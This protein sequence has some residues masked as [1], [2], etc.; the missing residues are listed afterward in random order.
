MGPQNGPPM[1]LGRKRQHQQ[2]RSVIQ[3]TLE[4][5][6]AWAQIQRPI[7][8]KLVLIKFLQ[9]KMVDDINFMRKGFKGDSLPIHQ[10]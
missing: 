8:E 3:P 2:K 7:S 6:R 10:V 1:K 5:K 4:V 9:R